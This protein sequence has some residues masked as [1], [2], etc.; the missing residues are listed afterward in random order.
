MEGNRRIVLQ[1][2]APTGE[3]DSFGQRKQGPAIPHPVWAVR[4]DKPSAGEGM[5]ATGIEGGVWA[6]HYTIREESVSKRPTEDWWVIDE[7]GV[8]LELSGVFEKHSGP[9]ARRLVLVCERTG[10]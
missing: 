5:L 2:P 9:R 4:E 6:R 8:R 3:K 10:T 7:D 1:E